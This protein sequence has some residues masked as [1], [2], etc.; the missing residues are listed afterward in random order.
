[1]LDALAA[2]C[3]SSDVSLRLRPHMKFS[4][5]L[6]YVVACAAS[7]R[8][9]TG[10]AA[11]LTIKSSINFHL[12]GMTAFISCRIVYAWRAFRHFRKS[13]CA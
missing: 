4:S 3:L 10:A 5:T 12:E 11:D 1:M 8:A 13:R 6:I 9:A 2:P 7:L